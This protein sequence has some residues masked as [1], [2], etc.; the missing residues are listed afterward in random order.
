MCNRHKRVHKSA[1]ST[2]YVGWQNEIIWA[3]CNQTSFDKVLLWIQ[4]RSQISGGNKAWN[5]NN[6]FSFVI[7]FRR[8]KLCDELNWN[9]RTMRIRGIH[10]F[11]FILKCHV[12]VFRR[13]FQNIQKMNPLS[14]SNPFRTTDSTEK[15]QIQVN[16]TSTFPS[17]S[18]L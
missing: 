4:C 17:K 16:S 5:F 2:K 6:N 8:I 13:K 15:L 18:Q 9:K 1:L 3:V 7:E 11:L 12:S 10:W 14:K